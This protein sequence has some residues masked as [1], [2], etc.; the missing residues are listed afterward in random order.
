MTRV[1]D[2]VTALYRDPALAGLAF[3][4]TGS[5]EGATALMRAAVPR[6]VARGWRLSRGLS[7]RMSDALAA[8]ACERWRSGELAEVAPSGEPDTAPSVYAPPAVQAPAPAP[9]APPAPAPEAAAAHNP[10][11]PPALGSTAASAPASR[12]V[13]QTPPVSPLVARTAAP[14]TTPA[15]ERQ[16]EPAEPL[17]ELDLAIA[18]LPDDIRLAMA[19]HYRLDRD[20]RGIA[21]AMRLGRDDVIELLALGR[22]RLAATLGTSEQDMER[23]VVT[24]AG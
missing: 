13:P 20:A 11:A 15:T 7:S 23:L 18:A 1:D 19:L 14:V 2:A 22:S 5:V 24:G 8:S 10:Y 12:P 16:P 4:L 17:S 21:R 6:A 9:V 3:A